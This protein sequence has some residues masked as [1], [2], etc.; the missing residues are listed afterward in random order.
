MFLHNSNIGTIF[1]INE[2]KIFIKYNL[3][4]LLNIKLLL[5][6][7]TIFKYNYIETKTPDFLIF[8]EEYVWFKGVISKKKR[9][10]L[11]EF[12]AMKILYPKIKQRIF[13]FDQ[14][15]FVWSDELSDYYEY[16]NNNIK[17]IKNKNNITLFYNKKDIQILIYFLE[18][19]IN[20]S[21]FNVKF[22]INNI[23]IEWDFWIIFN[24]L[25]NNNE[26]KII[27]SCE[28]LNTYSLNI[29]ILY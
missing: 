29:N 15:D 1:I 27:H 22:I 20:F 8:Y 7:N 28:L 16:T 4:I 9:S 12:W 14:L 21:D 11:D 17:V 2:K 6:I 18:E 25:C 24:N 19:I 26:I 5:N 13:F 10:Y 3:K 23:E